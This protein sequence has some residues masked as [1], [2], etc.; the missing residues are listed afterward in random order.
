[1]AIVSRQSVHDRKVELR[2]SPSVDDI[3]HTFCGSV[4]LIA[5][6]I[7]GRMAIV[8]FKEVLSD[9]FH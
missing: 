3:P 9:Y 8:D 1:M 6:I 2:Q 5:R 7:D 4:R